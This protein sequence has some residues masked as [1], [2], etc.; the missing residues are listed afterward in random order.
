MADFTIECKLKQIE[1]DNGYGFGVI[2]GYKESDEGSKYHYFRITND[3]Y[4][5][6]GYCNLNFD[7]LEWKSSPY[8]KNLEFNTL[9]VKKKGSRV[10]YYINER[11][12]NTHDMTNAGGSKLGLN[13]SLEQTI[14]IDHIYFCDSYISNFE[15]LKNYLGWSGAVVNQA[16]NI[17]IAYSNRTHKYTTALGV[18]EDIATFDMLPELRKRF[19][20]NNNILKKNRMAAKPSFLA[21][22]GDT[23][24][25]I[26][27]MVYGDVDEPE[28]K[29]LR[30]YRDRVLRKYALGRLFIEIYYRYSPSFVSRFRNSVNVNRI[31]KFVLDKI[32]EV[33]RT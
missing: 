13:V 7:D 16:L 17:C 11:H 3:G 8:I 31:I 33:V 30:G 4:Y 21:P 22:G 2:W 18:M 25:Y 6:C 14:H 15:V 29:I 32:V 12:V 10:E 5:A 27:T 23:L 24:C 19:D 20:E 28:V 26:A 9:L 1:E